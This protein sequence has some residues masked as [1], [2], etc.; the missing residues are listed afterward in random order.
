MRAS[1]RRKTPA[2]VRPTPSN[3]SERSVVESPGTCRLQL[4]G[5]AAELVP[6]S[7]AASRRSSVPPSTMDGYLQTPAEQTVSGKSAQSAAVSQA[8]GPCRQSLAQR[9][10]PA[11]EVATQRFS[12]PPQSASVAQLRAQTPDSTP[13]SAKQR[14]SAPAPSQLFPSV[15]HGEQLVAWARRS[16]QRFATQRKPLGHACKMHPPSPAPG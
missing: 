13:I 8:A 5:G 6:A 15:R 16:S 9:K 7:L 1:T 14:A 2:I 3:A 4:S 10:S 12:P 11:P